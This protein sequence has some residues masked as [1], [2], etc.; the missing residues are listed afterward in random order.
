MQALQ[1]CKN[2]GMRQWFRDGDVIGYMLGRLFYDA[3]FT[4]LKAAGVTPPTYAWMGLRTAVTGTWMDRNGWRYAEGRL[5]NNDLWH[6]SEPYGDQGP[7]LGMLV[8]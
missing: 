6:S 2:A 8:T 4:A 7:L 5:L 3:D 1:A